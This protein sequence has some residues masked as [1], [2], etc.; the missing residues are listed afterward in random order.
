MGNFRTLECF[1]WA[2]LIMWSTWFD[3]PIN[4]WSIVSCIFP[5][6]MDPQNTLGYFSYK[7]EFRLC[8]WCLKITKNS[9]S[10]LREWSE[11]CLHFEWTKV[12]QKFHKRYLASAK[13]KKFKWDI[14]VIF[15]QHSC[16][17]KNAETSESLLIF[18]KSW[19]V[20]GDANYS[21][22]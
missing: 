12:N 2:D 1:K 8:A 20:K 15:K 21:W 17:K 22:P 10:T 3:I 6:L 11:L 7:Y 14:W 9:H 5:T 19:F 13:I 16:F 4:Y 18:P